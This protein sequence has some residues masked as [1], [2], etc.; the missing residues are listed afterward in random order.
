MDNKNIVLLAIGNTGRGDDGL[1]WHLA[2]RLS[3]TNT[4]NLQIEYRYQLQV[5]DAL[6]ISQYST[7]IFADATLEPLENGYAFEPCLPA[8]HYFYSS[9]M[10]NPSTIL[11]LLACLYGKAP[12]AFLLTMSGYSWELGE[13]LTSMAEKNLSQAL[14]CL[15]NQV[16]WLQKSNLPAAVS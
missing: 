4:N 11:Y 14:I 15:Q 12:K 5:E 16:E 9:H 13:N 6:L 1:G 3:E 10:Q 8:D 2:D 7:V